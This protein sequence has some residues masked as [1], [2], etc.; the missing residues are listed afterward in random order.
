MVANELSWLWLVHRSSLHLVPV[1]IVLAA[2]DLARGRMSDLPGAPLF[3][4]VQAIILV[5]YLVLGIILLV[6]M[7]L[8]SLAFVLGGLAL[9]Y[10][11]L[12]IVQARA[13]AAGLETRGH[14][15]WRVRLG[16]MAAYLPIVGSA[17]AVWGAAAGW[18]WSPALGLMRFFGP[19]A[20][21][22]GPMLWLLILLLGPR[23]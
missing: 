13:V 20:A 15:R 23:T 2:V 12:G 9:A 3:I 8:V 17:M 10:L 22:V 1:V 18:G 4:T 7:L 21:I 5:A 19:L 16:A 6:P 11:M 14:G